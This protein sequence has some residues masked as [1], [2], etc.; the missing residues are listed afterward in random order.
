MSIGEESFILFPIICTDEITT[1][2][3]LKLIHLITTLSIE[4]Q[5]I[6]VDRTL[7]H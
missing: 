2:K 6:E 5:P 1:V 7:L 4:A 3:H